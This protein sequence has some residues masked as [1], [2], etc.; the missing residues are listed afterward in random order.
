MLYLNITTLETATNFSDPGLARLSVF[1]DSYLG[2]QF[3]LSNSSIPWQ[4]AA[5]AINLGGLTDFLVDNKNFN[6]TNYADYVNIG[7]YTLVDSG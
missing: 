2:K 3:N 6:Q 7:N 4:P 1:T 5:G